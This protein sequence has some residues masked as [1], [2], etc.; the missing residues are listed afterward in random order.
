MGLG[1]AA[2]E[3]L[4][5]SSTALTG[6][7]QLS[8]E[9]LI[10]A[11]FAMDSTSPLGRFNLAGLFKHGLYGNEDIGIHVGAG[12]GIGNAPSPKTGQGSVA[13]T[14]VG[15]AGLHFPVPGAP[16]IN[17]HLDGGPQLA[18]ID[19]NANF[20]IKALSPALGLSVFYLF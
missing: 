17:V 15:I 10:Q 5:L 1:L 4:T 11:F 19:G 20:A 6:V 8:Q 3:N 14:L 13:F 9:N 12:A 18:I 2:V 7:Y 16:R